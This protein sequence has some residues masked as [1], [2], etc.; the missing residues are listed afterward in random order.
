MTKRS[1]RYFKV[2]NIA[3]SNINFKNRVFKTNDEV[4]IQFLDHFAKK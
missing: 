4:L 1:R 3:N 2:K